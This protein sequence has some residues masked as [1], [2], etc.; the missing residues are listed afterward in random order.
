MSGALRGVIIDAPIE[1]LASKFP[2]AVLDYAV[3]IPFAIDP[4]VDF[5]SSVTVQAKPSGAGEI[6]INSLSVSDDILIITVAGGQ[7]GRLYTY[8][9][10]VAMQNGR[11][12]TFV[13]VQKVTPV[14][15]SDQ[16][17]P[18]PSRAF[19]P[20]TTWTYGPSLDFSQPR[21][22]MYIF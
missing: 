5:I 19:G 14:S 21:N 16:A 12:F 20:L 6:V 7:A 11:G 2:D 9:F 18:V 8:K 3:A 15:P 13:A 4:D 17:Q 10:A 1:V 22:S